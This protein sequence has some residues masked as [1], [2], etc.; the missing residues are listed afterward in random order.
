MC[1]RGRGGYCVSVGLCVYREGC[2]GRDSEGE[3]EM[4]N[5]EGMW[6]GRGADVPKDRLGVCLRISLYRICDDCV[7]SVSGRASLCTLAVRK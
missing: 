2:V 7:D 3:G 1:R 5:G 6:V 4:W